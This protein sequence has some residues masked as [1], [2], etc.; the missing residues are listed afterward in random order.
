MGK[1]VT[2]RFGALDV[3]INNA[4][5]FRGA[6]FIETKVSDFDEVVAANLRSVF[7]VTRAFVVGM[8]ARGSGHIFNM[9]SI[10]GLEAY[11]NGAAY[12][13]AK[14]GVT[15]LSHVLREELKN[16]GV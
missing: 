15:G 11:P 13:A 5:V 6:P 8:I 16:K 2:Q 7:L 4:G 12:C 9:S 10:A 14:F 3:L 1:A